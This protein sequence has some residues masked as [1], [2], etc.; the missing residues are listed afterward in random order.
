M[1]YFCHTD[2]ERQARCKPQDFRAVGVPVVDVP[3][4]SQLQDRPVL[5]ENVVVGYWIQDLLTFSDITFD[6]TEYC[7]AARNCDQ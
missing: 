7:Q 2:L 1:E 6:P 4:L 3:V 5:R